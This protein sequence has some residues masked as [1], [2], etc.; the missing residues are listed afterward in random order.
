[1]K[2]M[3]RALDI[4]RRKSNWNGRVLHEAY[5][6]QRR[7]RAQRLFDLKAGS[8]QDL[9]TAEADLRNAQANIEKAQSEVEKER[10]HLNIFGLPFD[11]PSAVSTQKDEEDD[12]PI[13]AP[14][15]GVILE[16][17]ATLGTVVNSGEEIFV[18]TNISSLWMIGAANEADLS[19]LH[20]GQQVRIEVRAFPDHVFAGRILKLGEELDPATRT[21]QIRIE[22]PNPQGLLKAE[23]YATAKVQQSGRR[24]ALVVPEEAIQEIDGVSM[25]FVQHSENEFRART[26]E[27]GEHASG[28]IEILQ[29]LQ[30]G[31]PVVVKG[32]F[33]LKSELLKA[34][35]Q[36]E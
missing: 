2:C 4:N 28:G 26:V 34:R 35:I 20:A 18:I 3:R 11:E 36:D 16:R 22:V 14:E 10:A 30:R 33:A 12:I 1:M 7:D 23:M 13:L 5:A 32:S 6:K 9:E 29:G 19:K 21:L 17:K 8:R 25:V 24:A 31:E 27:P 15:A